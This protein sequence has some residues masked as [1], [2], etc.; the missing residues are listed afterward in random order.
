MQHVFAVE[1]LRYVR[2]PYDLVLIAAARARALRRGAV[3]LTA[4]NADSPAGIALDEIASGALTP[5][6]LGELLLPQNPVLDQDRPER[7]AQQDEH[8]LLEG[9]TA[10]AAFE[11]PHNEA[12]ERLN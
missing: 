12:N 9:L 6:E 3:P 2:N 8:A 1:C 11:P 7:V 10:S 4:S 5:E